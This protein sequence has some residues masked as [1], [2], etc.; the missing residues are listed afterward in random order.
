MPTDNLDLRDIHLPDPISWWPPAIG[1]WLVLLGIIL[2][3]FVAFWLR[4]RWLEKNRSAKVLAQKELNFIHEE[5]QQHKDQKLLIEDLSTLLR[6]VCLSVFPRKNSAGLT[7]E[8]WLE[9]LDEVMQ[10]PYFS[11]GIGRSLITAPYEKNPKIDVDELFIL[12]KD[13]IEALP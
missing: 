2:L 6:R 1:W 10:K 11:E 5:F 7:G 8:K 9:F 3:L 12:C 13:W 4:K